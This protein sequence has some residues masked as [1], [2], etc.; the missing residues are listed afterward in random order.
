MAELKEDERDL[1]RVD[2]W[3]IKVN[4]LG[5]EEIIDTLNQ[6]ISKGEK[7]KYCTPVDANTVMLAQNDKNLR[8]AIFLSDITNVDS[9]LPAEFLKKA[10]YPINGRVATPYVM[11]AILS[12][13]NKN[14]LRIYFL[15]AKDSTLEKLNDVIRRRFPNVVIAGMRNGYFMESKNETIAKEI[16]ETTPDVVFIGMPSPKKE[17]FVISCK[18]TIDAGVLYC[19][20]GAFD[21]L[22]GV[23]P[24]PPKWLQ[25]GP[26]EG[27]L[28]IIRNPWTY[29]RRAI[30]CFK[31][32]S[33][34]KKWNTT[35]PN[36]NN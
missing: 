1:K 29:W 14:K 21:A 34:A 12:E 8:E 35:H 33:F 13:A 11:D 32:I 6:W 18:K 23:L 7:G 26:I 10:G 3:N 31:F 28:R 9:F 19:V 25:K 20:G 24:R 15:G 27:I 22:A 36:S 17:D 4:L 2:I 16:S 30:I 5:K